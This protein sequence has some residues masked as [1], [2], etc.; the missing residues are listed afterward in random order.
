[1]IRHHSQLNR[2][3]KTTK[4]AS[5]GVIHASDPTTVSGGGGGG[6]GGKR[7]EG[8]GGGMRKN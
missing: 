4:T 1:M 7:E 5:A 3:I 6:G 8:R 2:N